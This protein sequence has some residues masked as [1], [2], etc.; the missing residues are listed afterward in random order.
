MCEQR[1]QGVNKRGSVLSFREPHTC[2]RRATG[3]RDADFKRNERAVDEQTADERDM[4]EQTAFWAGAP[5]SR[6]AFVQ[7]NTLVAF[8]QRN[9]LATFWML[10]SRPRGSRGAHALL[11]H[12]PARNQA[13]SGLKGVHEA[14]ELVRR[15]VA[16]VLHHTLVVVLKNSENGAGGNAGVHVG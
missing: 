4:D 7:R 9:T 15:Q 11:L 10:F 3:A 8:V 6:V 12:A 14:L 13:S 16:L 1:G 2:S 5:S